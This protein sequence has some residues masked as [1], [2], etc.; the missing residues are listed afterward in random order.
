MSLDSIP[1]LTLI[2][3]L[4]LLGAIAVAAAP[5]QYARP[6][7]LGAALITWILSLLLV[8]GFSATPERGGFFQYVVQA[9]W[10]P[11]FGIK[12]KLG[13]DGLSLVLVVLTTTLSWISILASFN[14]IKTR[15]K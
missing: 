8:I 5:A 11:L 15:I 2:V 3:F 7:A 12:F 10:I 1:I 6:L 14:P 9:D 4:P 13:V